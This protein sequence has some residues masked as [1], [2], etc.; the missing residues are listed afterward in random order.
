MANP[1][2]GKCT[3]TGTC[4]KDPRGKGYIGQIAV[5]DF[6]GDRVRRTV[7][8]ATPEIVKEKMAAIR[9]N[10]YPEKPAPRGTVPRQ[11]SVTT[12]MARWISQM[13]GSRSKVENYRRVLNRYVLPQIGGMKMEDVKPTDIEN[14]LAMIHSSKRRAYVHVVCGVAFKRAAK[15][16]HIDD[17]P[18]IAI[19]APRVSKIRHIPLTLDQVTR[20][21]ESTKGT[22]YYALIITAALTGLREGELFGLQRTDVDLV[23]GKIYVRNALKEI[24]GKLYL[25]EPKSVAGIRCVDLPAVVTDALCVQFAEIDA[26]HVRPELAGYVFLSKQGRRIRCSNFTGRTWP[27]ILNRA[28]LPH[29][30]FH[31]LR[32]TMASLL[33]AANVHPKVVQERIGHSSISVTMDTYSHLIPT[34]QREAA[35]K[36]NGMFAH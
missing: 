25:E 6:H 31:S 16:G 24:I 14:L 29:F 20:L 7:R 18:C 21:I 32:H 19:D 1:N 10:G 30:N 35:D 26:R 12:Y 36:L 23:A 2:K 22:P 27:R 34:M 8:G 11:E 13:Q 4:W 15:Y 9:K 17:D 3:G 33:L 5:I 28:G